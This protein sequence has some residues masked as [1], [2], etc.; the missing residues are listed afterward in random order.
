MY[1]KNILKE[2]YLLMFGLCPSL[3]ARKEMVLIAFDLNHCRMCF[4]PQFLVTYRLT[5]KIPRPPLYHSKLYFDAYWSWLPRYVKEGVGW[6]NPRSST[7]NLQSVFFFENIWVPQNSL[8]AS[9]ENYRFQIEQRFIQS[10][11]SAVQGSKISNPLVFSMNGK[12]TLTIQE[13]L[14]RT[15]RSWLTSHYD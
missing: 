12:T 2:T 10:I 3:V 14:C 11:K 13:D 8:L 9:S 7:Y 6:G 5:A 15:S 4:W 1:G